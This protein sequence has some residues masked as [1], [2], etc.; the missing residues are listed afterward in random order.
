M[1]NVA[2]YHAR[3]RRRNLKSVTP[4]IAVSGQETTDVFIKRAKK[5]EGLFHFLYIF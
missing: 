1:R 3:E 5:I 4:D 2:V